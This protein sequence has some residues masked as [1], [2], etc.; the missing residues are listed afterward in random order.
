MGRVRVYDSEHL[1]KNMRET[2]TDKKSTKR[3][4]FPFTW[5]DTWQ[6][7]GDSLAIA[8]SSDKWAD[9]GDLTP[10]KH[11]AESPNRAF[12]VPGFLRDMDNPKKEWPTIG[13]HVSFEDVPMPKHFA[14]LALFEE[15]NLKLHTKGTDEEPRFG[16]GDEG[17]VKVTVGHATL[18]GGMIRWSEESSRGDQPFLFVYTKSGPLMLIVGEELDVL[19]DGIVG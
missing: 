3:T 13:P 4:K 10:Y 11:L 6:N 18:G 19:A 7:V 16:R 5:P 12:C 9:E 15:V 2:F 17:V 1:A 14:V 8:Y